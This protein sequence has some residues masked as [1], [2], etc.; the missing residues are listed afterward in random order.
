MNAALRAKA[1]IVD[2]AREWPAIAREAG[3]PAY[4]LSRYVAVLA[5]IPAA[6]S[7]VGACL[8][9]VVVPG[10][11][12]ARAPL[13][14]GL[15]GAVFGYVAICLIVLILALTVY[16]AAP[17]FGGRRDFDSAFKLAAYSFTPVCLAGICLILP[18]LRFLTLTGFYGAYLLWLGLPPLVQLPRRNALRL[19][20]LV[21]VCAFALASLAATAQRTM[22]GT[23]GL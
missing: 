11:G 23:P 2:P 16:L 21:T 5:V 6:A 10:M 3:D 12:V 13:A 20:A 19:A 4:L 17:S 14:D 18:G 8:I 9:G 15:F 7:F 22:F 1:I